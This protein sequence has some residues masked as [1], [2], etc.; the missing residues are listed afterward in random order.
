MRQLD[1]WAD[2]AGSWLRLYRSQEAVR[3]YQFAALRRLL[4][5]A[6]G[7]APFYIELLRSAGFEPGGLGSLEDLARLPI[8]SKADLQHNQSVYLLNIGGRC[9]A[10]YE[11][12]C[13]I[14]PPAR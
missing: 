3:A 10:T 14:L 9:E 7:E 8:V 6:A 5:H 11:N 12:C 13:W 4:A 2:Y 1:L